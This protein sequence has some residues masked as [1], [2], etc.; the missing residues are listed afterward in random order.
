MKSVLN[1]TRNLRLLLMLSAVG[2]FVSAL[3]NPSD[4]GAK[5]KIIDNAYLFSEM[6]SSVETVV[7]KNSKQVSQLSGIIGQVKKGQEVLEIHRIRYSRMQITLDDGRKGWVDIP[8]VSPSDE[9]DAYLLHGLKLSELLVKPGSADPAT[10]VTSENKNL[11]FKRNTP[12]RVIEWKHEAEKNKDRIFHSGT[13]WAKIEIEGYSGW[14]ESSRFRFKGQMFDS[15]IPAIWY[16]VRWFSK[17]LGDGFWA[18][19]FILMILVIPMSISYAI[20]RFISS[21]LRFLPNFVLYIIILFF[22]FLIYSNTYMSIYDASAFNR[23][24]ILMFSLFG[25]LVFVVAIGSFAYV[26]KNIY[27]TRCP[28][29]RHWKGKVYDTQKLS[30]TWWKT[31]TTTHYSDGTTKRNVSETTIQSWKDFCSCS[32]CGNCWAIQRTE[33]IES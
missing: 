8:V 21:G 6:S 27:E 25:I 31:T 7:D 16:P 13:W 22:A 18:G 1:F 28:D 11:K 12:L 3:G 26:R 29:C 19:L 20:A 17:L 9:K 32:H 4:S 15:V 30:E 24:E 5:R 14:V 23:G 2:L 33:T 10:P